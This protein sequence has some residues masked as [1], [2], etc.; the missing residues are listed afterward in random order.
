ML[1]EAT[2]T[3]PTS[4]EP[5]NHP[6]EVDAATIRRTFVCEQRTPCQSLSLEESD[7]LWFAV[8]TKYRR[9]ERMCGA[10]PFLGRCAYN[11]VATRATHGV[12]AGQVLPGD[13]LTALEPIYERFLEIF[14]KRAAV[15]LGD[16][17][18]P[19]MPNTGSAR[20]A[21]RSPSPSAAA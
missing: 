13:K 3:K 16:R 10:C 14:K 2:F 9:A 20:R 7:E 12:W 5:A 21:R 19:P 8:D 4:A 18:L 17:P 15:E 1:I 11:A 6:A